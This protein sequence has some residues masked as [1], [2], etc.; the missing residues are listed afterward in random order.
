MKKFPTKMYFP[1]NWSKTT[2]FSAHGLLLEAH[3]LWWRVERAVFCS[4]LPPIPVCLSQMS[5]H[6][7][8]CVT[9]SHWGRPYSREVA[10]FPLVS[11]PLKMAVLAGGVH[12]RTRGLLR[13]PPT[14][15]SPYYSNS[16]WDT[17]WNVG[18]D[19]GC[20]AQEL[21]FGALKSDQIG[22]TVK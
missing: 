16:M 19:E 2:A 15:Q 14:L 9:S 7:L 11:S 21:T 8:T 3:W 5:P 13:G 10:A 1:L 6:S 17:L 12:V 20:R 22:V 4:D 18:H